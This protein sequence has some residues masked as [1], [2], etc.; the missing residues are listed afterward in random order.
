MAGHSKWSKVKRIKGPL[1]VKRGALFS[2]LSKEIA[3]AAKLGGGDLGAN[4]RLRAAMQGA[5]DQNMP[6]DTGDAFEIL[7]PVDR[8][9]AV[10][11]ALRAG[12]ITPESQKLA[13]LPTTLATLHD[14]AIAQQVMRLHDAF[15][16]NDDA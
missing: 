7:T 13:S 4:I 9:Y 16:D 15:E 14:E 3:L 10:G 5:R 2:R 6:S 8:F 1:D 11:E 12:G